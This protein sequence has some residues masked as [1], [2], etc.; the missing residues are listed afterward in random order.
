VIGNEEDA[1]DVLG[2]RGGGSVAAAGRLEVESYPEVAAKIVA[3][4]PGVRFVATSL[5]ESV[6][7]THNNWGGMLYEAHGGKVWFAPTSGG[8]YCPYQ[9]RNIVDRVGA[10]DS[11]AAGLIYALNDPQLR[12]P[13]RAVA[14]AAAA[15]CLAHSVP[16]DF[17]YCSRAEVL[18][19]M[20]GDVSGRVKR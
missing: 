6:S 19:L 5:R 10:G 18:A 20:G 9:I 12:E 7:A 16:G 14:F 3:A 2:I 11:F 1:D 8:S 13:S 15:G 17:N 4:Y